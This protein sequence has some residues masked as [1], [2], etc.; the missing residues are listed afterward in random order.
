VTGVGAGVAPEDYGQL[1][2]L[3][4]LLGANLGVT[5]K[6]TDM[7]LM[8]GARQIGITG[9]SIAPDLYMAIGISGKLNHMLGV[10]AAGTI[11]AIN[12][13]PQAPVFGA[14]DI[15]IVAEWKTAVPLL[16]KALRERMEQ[17]LTPVVRTTAQWAWDGH[18]PGS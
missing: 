17:T 9:R 8:P 4:D 10:R 2:E 18:R 11:L 16:Y 1:D 3:T 13:D 6:V 12:P 5:R 15:G 7:Q 14:S